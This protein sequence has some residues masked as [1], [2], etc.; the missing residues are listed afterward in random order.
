MGRDPRAAPTP[1][2]ME[3]GLSCVRP[4]FKARFG[5]G[6]D[7]DDGAEGPVWTT[8]RE[9]SPCCAGDWPR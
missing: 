2:E 1:S 8:T 4:M 9:A 6:I 5:E 7:D 3:T